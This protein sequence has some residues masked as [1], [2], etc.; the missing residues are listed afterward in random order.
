MKLDFARN[1]RRNML[2]SAVNNGVKTVIPFVNRTLFLWLLG[3]AYLGL[4]G[5]FGSVLGVLS[6]A[7][8]G[9]STAIVSSMYKPIAEDDEE[10]VCAYLGFYR[11]VYRWIGTAVL[12]IGL[13]LL[14]FLRHLVHGAVPPDVDLHVLYLVHLANSALSYFVF[15][16]RGPVLSAYQRG[17]VA[18]NVR[19]VLAL[20]QFAAVVLVLVLTRS[21][22][23]YVGTT[24]LFTALT[25]VAIMVQSKRLFPKIGPRGALAPE[26]RRQVVA[27]VR[28]IFMH[29]VGGVI[30]YQTDN[31]VVSAFLGLVAVAAYGNYYYVVTAVAGFVATVYN[32][33]TGGFG[34]RIHTESKEANFRTFL[35]ALRLSLVVILWCSAMMTALYQPFIAVW[36]KGNPDLARHFATPL[37]MVVYFYVNQARQMLLTFKTAAALW[38]PDRWKPLVGGAANL[39]MN[40]AFVILLPDEWKLDGVILSTILSYVLIQIPWESR[41]LFTRF[42]GPAEA[43]AYWGRQARF[44]AL[45]VALCAATWGCARLVPL[46]GFAGLLAKAAAA[47]AF[48]GAAVLAL[49]RRDLAAARARKSG[50]RRSPRGHAGGRSAPRAC[51][52]RLA[53]QPQD[54][55]FGRRGRRLPP[56]LPRPQGNRLSRRSFAGGGLGAEGHGRQGQAHLSRPRRAPSDSHED[57]RPLA[58]AVGRGVSPKTQKGHLNCRR[59]GRNARSY[60]RLASSLRCWHGWAA[61]APYFRLNSGTRSA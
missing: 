53:P 21:Y 30:S 26:K 10:L 5:L 49:F 58:R 50:A 43:R 48:S 22:Y 51:A 52:H 11:T 61:T 20:A 54:S 37:L 8:L 12:C 28:H 42:F 6:L 34:N 9:F 35:K 17:D 19:T 3:P 55:R 25:N 15:A 32:A 47:A 27:D 1:A 46:S 38:R 44:A 4:N 41:V 59:C 56:G 29:K 14:P 7:E 57:V 33:M 36:T 60:P 16:Y 23:L 31:L 39:A 13:C 18:M 24:V 2:A 45:A 40:V